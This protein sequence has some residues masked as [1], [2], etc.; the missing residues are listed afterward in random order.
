MALLPCTFRESDASPGVPLGERAGFSIRGANMSSNV[1]NVDITNTG[2]PQTQAAFQSLNVEVNQFA[3]T[4]NNASASAARS[5]GS[6]IERFAIRQILYG[7]TREVEDFVKTS[8][9]AAQ[10]GEKAQAALNS[11]I[12]RAGQSYQVARRAAEEFRNLT[13]STSAQANEATAAAAAI[14]FRS[15]LTSKSDSA[16]QKAVADIVASQGGGSAEAVKQLQKLAD[17]NA[18]SL[19]QLTGKT[20]AE[21]ERAY[22]LLHHEL[23][24][25]LTDMEKSLARV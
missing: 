5:W 9:R 4:V 18:E 21:A 14:A 23:P 20:S 15:G 25:D 16:I 19:K 10:E 17:G 24:K 13:K 12:L 3:Q 22:A 2:V 7:A 11:E 6:M 1:V 8:I